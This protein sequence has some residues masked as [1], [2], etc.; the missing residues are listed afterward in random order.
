M[1][2]FPK[3]FQGFAGIA[4]GAFT[5]PIMLATIPISFGYSVPATFAKAAWKVAKYEMLEF[6]PNRRECRKGRHYGK[7]H[8]DKWY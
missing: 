4:G 1:I 8:H 5:D 3:L 6:A 2:F 7:G